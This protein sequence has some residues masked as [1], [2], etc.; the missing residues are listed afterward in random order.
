MAKDGGTGQFAVESQ[1]GFDLGVAQDLHRKAKGVRE[2]FTPDWYLNS[3]FFVGQQWLFWNGGRLDRPVLEPWRRT[4]VDNRFMPILTGRTARKTKDRPSFVV[5]PATADEDDRDAAL[6]GEKV[7]EYDWRHMGLQAKLYNAILFSEIMGAGFWKIYWDPTLGK[8]VEVIVDPETG[9]A[10]TREDGTPIKVSDLGQIPAGLGSRRIAQGDL[11]VDVLSPF[12]ILPDPLATSLDTAEWIIEE[13]VRSLEYVKRRWDYDATADAPA[14]VGPV[15]SRLFSSLHYSGDQAE[16]YKG[17]KV[18]ELWMRPCSKYP[19]GMRAVWANDQLLAADAAPFDPMPYVMFP[20]V[21]V[22]NRFWPT[23]IGT[24]LRPPQVELNKVQ[25]Q[26]YENT[27]RFG[28][29]SMLISRQANVD[30]YGVPGEKIY[31]DS[32]VTDAVPSFLQ[33][34]EMPVYVREQIDRITDTMNEIAGVHEV[35]NASVPAGITAASAINLLQEADDTRLGPE[36]HAIED[37]LALAG[38]KILKLRARYNDDERTLH[39]M[40]EDND[41]DI[42]AFKN[43][44]IPDDPTV[45]VQAGSAMPRSKAAKQA[46]MLE[47]LAL[48]FQYGISLDPADLRKFLKDYEVASLDRLFSSV[49]NDEA[50]VNR[51]HRL[52]SQGVALPINDFDDDDAHIELHDNYRKTQRYANLPGPL[53]AVHDA[54]VNAHKERQVQTINAQ[55]QAQTPRPED[56]AAYAQAEQKGAQ[57]GQGGS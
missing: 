15:E 4:P 21:V 46:A 40:G 24:Q 25:G 10:M 44:M 1:S 26:L 38:T 29:P 20:G 18:Y 47:V 27:A 6:I 33:P 19:E 32:T 36:I 31:Y 57:N 34:A 11:V 14:Q 5:Q 3:A 56:V 54:H 13:K 12:E 37:G 39:L 35:S 22:P 50:Q 28:N 43:S 48:V 2:R 9:E 16:E 55:L 30:Y 23:A 53:K 52:M 42:F 41:W 45:E 51:E 7:L 17:V 49:G 8:S